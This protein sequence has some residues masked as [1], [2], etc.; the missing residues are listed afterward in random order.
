MCQ[1]PDQTFTMQPILSFAD[2]EEEQSVL[3]PASGFC[4]PG[5]LTQL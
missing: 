1:S 4:F 2:N 5:E 3:N